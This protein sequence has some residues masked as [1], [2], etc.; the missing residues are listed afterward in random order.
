MAVTNNNNNLIV[1]RW[2]TETWLETIQRKVYGH[3][4]KRGI[5]YF[6]PDFL[7]SKS[8]GD[9]LTFGF[10]SKLK[11]IPV[12]AGGTVTGNSE[13][14]DLQ[15]YKMAIDVCRVS[16]NSPNIDT[17]EQQRTYVNFEEIGRAQLSQ[18]VRE[19][20]ETSIFYQAAGANPTSIAVDGTTYTSTDRRFVQGL[21]TI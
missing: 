12:G 20:I 7:G 2:E 13:A 10:A 9:E 17:I 3:L 15:S 6:A 8:R 1:K 14:L 11:A 21:N 5:I 4:L 18:R 16:V 19:L